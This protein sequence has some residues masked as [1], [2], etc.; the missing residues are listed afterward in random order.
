[1]KFESRYITLSDLPRE[2]N[3]MFPL[4]AIGYSLDNPEVHSQA[5]AFDNKFEIGIRTV[6]H[7]DAAPA[8]MTIDGKDYRVGW[9]H[10]IIKPPCSHFVYKQ[11]AQRD[12][13]IFVFPASTFEAFKELAGSTTPYA[14]EI[15]LSPL[16]QNLVETLRESLELIGTPGACDRLDS[17][18]YA[19]LSELLLLRSHTR[20][21]R[22]TYND[23]WEMREIEG[24]IRAHCTEN[25]TIAALAR[26]FHMSRSTIFR[27]WK[28]HYSISPIQHL[29][30]LRMQEACRLLRETDLKIFAIAE[31]VC[32]GDPAYFCAAFKR[33]AGMSPNQYR[34]K[35][36][37]QI[38][39]TSNQ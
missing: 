37:T 25:L 21:S 36:R 7:G 12:I 27:K 17:Q 30:N 10:V 19:L 5:G 20:D 32:M 22:S 34:Q 31:Q 15:P 13:F 2:L 39:C 26:K 4:E 38:S 35:M 1:M 11:L 8:E 18:A 28:E 23:D 6:R 3:A 24:Y 14:W 16:W 29:C 33:F 9:P